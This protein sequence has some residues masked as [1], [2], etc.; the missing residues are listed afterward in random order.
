M[1]GWKRDVCNGF[2]AYNRALRIA[3]H[4]KTQTKNKIVN[5]INNDNKENRFTFATEPFRLQPPVAEVS[6]FIVL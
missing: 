2:W 6:I 5:I 4:H 3:S 1:D